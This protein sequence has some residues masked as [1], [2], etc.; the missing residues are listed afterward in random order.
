MGV[1]LFTLFVWAGTAGAQVVVDRVHQNASLEVSLAGGK[2]TVSL[3]PLTSL[4]AHTSAMYGM[5]RQTGVAYYAVR[6]D[7]AAKACVDQDLLAA[8]EVKSRTSAPTVMSSQFHPAFREAVAR[9]ASKKMPDSAAIAAIAPSDFGRAAARMWDCFYR[10][11]WERRFDTLA[12]AFRTMTANVH[13]AEAMAHMER[14]TGRKWTG[15]A[16]VFATEGVGKS[17]VWVKPN[18]SV[19]G[20]GE[21]DDGGFVHEGLH[22]MLKEEWA[23]DARIQ[24]LMAK[25]GFRDPYWGSNWPGKYEQ[26]L[27]ACLDIWI[28][29]FHKRYPEAKVVPNYLEGVRAGDLAQVAWPLVKTHAET[30]S[31]SIEDL[32]FELIGRAESG[33]PAEVQR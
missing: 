3:D 5:N 27:V 12:E 2:L 31:R 14:V 11:Y 9:G 28:R 19:G 20:V 22:L 23:R 29:G 33:G 26:A 30:P 16:W 1:L 24:A 32:M 15:D 10:A 13:W 7:G 25:R 6:E 21:W 17:A 18:I 4:L 8:L